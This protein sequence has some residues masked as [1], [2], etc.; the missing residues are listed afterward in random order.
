MREHIVE[1]DAI[2]DHALDQDAPELPAKA[3][4]MT[5]QDQSISATPET[6]RSTP[7]DVLS[8]VAY[9]D[10]A[11]RSKVLVI[12][13]WLTTF[14]L[15]AFAWIAAISLSGRDQHDALQRAQRDTAN[16]ARI[17][18]E[19]T[20]R[21]VAGTDRILSF[22]GYDLKRL[23][24][25]SPLL[26]Y[27]MRNATFDGDVLL[28]LTVIDANGFLVQSSAEEVPAGINVA[29]REH[30]Q[31]HREGAVKGLFISQPV[32]GRA[33]GKWSIQLSR[34][35]ELPDGSFGGIIVASLDP[36]YFSRIFDD[37]DVG[38]QGAISIIGRDGFLR[39]RNVMDEKIIG[40]DMSASD[41]HLAA[42]SNRK[43]FFAAPAPSTV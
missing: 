17:I 36:F 24:A 41:V 12:G 15:A 34:R 3:P 30:F 35:V 37:V 38:P 19:Q 39:A 32:F 13:V 8:A 11:G 1:D 5:E 14:V 4:A 42:R 9:A 16:L 23:G 33:S 40:M 2:D 31:V 7:E 10:G 25:S 26:R 18:A 22:I 20:T 21:A 6:V 43:A 28:Q 29:D 27:I